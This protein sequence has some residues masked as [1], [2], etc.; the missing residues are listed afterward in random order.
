MQ[1]AKGLRTALC[2]RIVHTKSQS[3]GSAVYVLRVEDVESGLQWVVP[4]SY[5]EYYTL[6]KELASLSK[7]SKEVQFLRKRFIFFSTAKLIEI[8][9]VELEQYTRKMLHILTVY[10]T[11]DSA[12][13]KSLRHLQNFL[14]VDKYMDTVH[15]PLIDDQ[16]YI[17]LMAYRLMNDFT[18][19][20]CQQ[21]VRFITSVDLDSITEQGPDGYKAV[22]TF[23]RDALA[24][25]EAFVQ[26]Q[27]Q[28]QMVQ[29]LRGRRPGLTAEESFVRKCIRRQ[30]EAALYLPLHRTVFR[31]VCS[32]LAQRVR[33]LAE[34]ITRVKQHGVFPNKVLLVD[35]YIVQARALPAAVTTFRRLVQAY[36]PL[37]QE[38][39]FEEFMAAVIGLLQECTAK[40]RNSKAQV[41]GRFK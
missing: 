21:C 40:H 10:A 24:E 11:T 13:S 4:R 34:A 2:V 5:E 6:N 16:R 19:P 14:G 30:V 35:T 18:S 26:A 20:A 7:Y 37:D 9:I 17:E 23:M 28:Q 32:Y 31:I 41:R 38:M 1:Q 29:T 22:L 27:Y 36:L 25:V 33:A 3:D 8:R 39:L 15:P 12:A